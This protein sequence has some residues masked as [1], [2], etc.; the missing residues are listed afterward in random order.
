[1]NPDTRRYMKIGDLD[2]EIL[3]KSDERE[4]F[5]SENLFLSTG[6]QSKSRVGSELHG[7]HSE[8]TDRN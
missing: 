2:M 7:Q 3:A 1:M 6:R 4:I 8:N 5:G